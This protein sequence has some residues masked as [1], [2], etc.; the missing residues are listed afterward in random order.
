MKKSLDF[1]ADPERGD[2]EGIGLGTLVAIKSYFIL[3]IIE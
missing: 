2:V 1:I 3:T